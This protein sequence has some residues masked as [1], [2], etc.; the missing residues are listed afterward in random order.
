MKSKELKI[1]PQHYFVTDDFDVWFKE[2]SLQAGLFGSALPI[3]VWYSDLMK[4]FPYF[5]MHKWAYKRSRPTE[6][7]VG[8]GEVISPN[9]HKFYISGADGDDVPAL[10]AE[11]IANIVVEFPKAVLYM[12]GIRELK[13]RN[14]DSIIPWD[15]VE[16]TFAITLWYG[17]LDK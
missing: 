6:P 13:E 12:P 9:K 4:A 11:R 3:P 2:L 17:D 7:M 8:Y 1:A 5:M 10:I 16:S 14:V 15:H